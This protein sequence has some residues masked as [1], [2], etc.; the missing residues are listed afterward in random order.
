MFLDTE[1]IS[2]L[3]QPGNGACSSVVRVGKGRGTA[4]PSMRRQVIK[5]PREQGLV[6]MTVQ[7]PTANR[8][9]WFSVLW[10]L[11]VA[12]TLQHKSALHHRTSCSPNIYSSPNLG[13]QPT[14]LVI[15]SFLHLKFLL[16]PKLHDFKTLRSQICL[17]PWAMLTTNF[18][19]SSFP[20]KKTM[21]DL[22]WCMELFN[23]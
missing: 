13:V 12:E 11:L 1:S 21:E 15:R 16:Q 10:R 22:T 17:F 7:L 14:A 19:L 5:W 3:P 2:T 6:V 18:P 20:T 9:C 8:K 23:G 4:G